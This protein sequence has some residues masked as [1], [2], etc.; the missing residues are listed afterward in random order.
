V[1]RYI[2][3][4][5]AA[6]AHRIDWYADKNNGN[7]E[8]ITSPQSSEVADRM[9]GHFNAISGELGNLEKQLRRL[10]NAEEMERKKQEEKKG[11]KTFGI[12]W[13]SSFALAIAF[14]AIAFARM[15]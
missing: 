13:R 3:E 14:A 8:E 9:K 5:E 7:E 1:Q 4:Q 2:E 6:L 11:V 10:L 12:V 15:T